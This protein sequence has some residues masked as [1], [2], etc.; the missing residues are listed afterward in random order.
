MSEE[1][2][3]WIGWKR[4][5]L[6]AFRHVRAEAIRADLKEE[7][8]WLE[9]IV[10][11]LCKRDRRAFFD[12]VVVELEKAG[13]AHDTR[14][15]MAKLAMLGRPKKGVSSR[16]LLPKVKTLEGHVEQQMIWFN[17]F[18]EVEAAHAVD[19][20]VLE[21]QQL[22][23]NSLFGSMELEDM[24]SLSQVTRKIRC[25]KNGKAP[26]PVPNEVLKAG[27][28]ILAKH[29]HLLM[30]KVA[31]TAREPLEWKSGTAVPLYKKGAYT[32]PKNYRSIFLSD[33]VAK[34]SHSCIRDRL[35]DTYEIIASPTCFGGR[36]GKS[37]D[38]GHHLLQ[39]FLHCAA[40][41]QMPMGMVFLDLHS[42]FYHVLREGLFGDDFSESAVCAFL[43]KTGITLEDIQD[44]CEQAREDA[45]LESC[46]SSLRNR[47]RDAMRA[48]HFRVKGLSQVAQTSRGTHPGDPIGD[49]LF[50]IIM[51]RILCDVRDELG[52][53]GFRNVVAD[54]YCPQESAP[55][56]LEISFFDDVAI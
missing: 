40:N 51:Q 9:K 50:N 7:L 44:Y 14:L 29:M 55:Q 34:L 28:E 25:L 2:I 48:T 22:G 38:M 26:G 33:A 31:G 39:S 19:P 17:L 56:F 15:V 36:R 11:V 46:S 20:H 12:Q 21:K 16:K 43:L 24:P 1:A 35:L 37:T 18:S 3:Q 45:V 10:R 8:R 47:V 54:G 41:V 27:G 6:D 42:A 13:Q 53:I 23:M 5:V 32:D 30:I 49:I 52:R 4:H